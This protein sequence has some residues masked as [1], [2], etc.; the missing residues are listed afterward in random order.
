[1]EEGESVKITQRRPVQSVAVRILVEREMEI[2]GFEATSSFKS[3]CKADSQ[4]RKKKHKVKAELPDKLATEEQAAAFLDSCN[5]AVYTVD[6]V[7][8]KPGKRS[9]SAPF[10]TSTL[11]Q[12]ASSK[13]GFSVA[14]TMMIAQKLYE[15]GHITYMRT[16]SV[17][18]SEQ[19]ISAAADE[20]SKSMVKSILSQDG[21]RRNQAMPGGTQ[22]IRPTYI[23]TEEA[24]SSADEK[25]KLYKLIWRRTMASQ[26]ARSKAGENHSEY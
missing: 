13:L 21:T 2:N 18:L 25:K 4:R 8:V 22:A 7:S 11:Q 17:N 9:P 1:M 5:G 20:I 24:G 19:A 12:E 23:E 10:T 16:D 6:D 14:R 3:K 15:E 26:M